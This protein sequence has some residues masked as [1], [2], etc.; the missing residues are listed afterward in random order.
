MSDELCGHADNSVDAGY[1]HEGSVGAMK[2]AIEKLTFDG[3][4]IEK[5]RPLRQ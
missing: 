5:G 4:R 1:V 3:F 2:A